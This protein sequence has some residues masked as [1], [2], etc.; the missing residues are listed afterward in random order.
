MEFT[1]MEQTISRPAF[2]FIPKIV[3]QQLIAYQPG[4]PLDF[5]QWGWVRKPKGEKHN[6]PMLLGFLLT[7]IG[8][9]T[10]IG[11]AW[12]IN[13]AVNTMYVSDAAVA[14]ILFMPILLLVI[15]PFVCFQSPAFCVIAFNDYLVFA[16]GKRVTVLHWQRI[17]S[18]ERKTI[19]NHLWGNVSGNTDRYTLRTHTGQR[20]RWKVSEH[21]M[22]DLGNIISAHI[23]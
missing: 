13:D 21:V 17:A 1:I 15:G 3:E 18:Y 8:L 5:F 23:G 7:L 6:S 4:E 16:K 10:T 19:V 12:A 20:L 22:E 9:V 2:K 14:L 11:A